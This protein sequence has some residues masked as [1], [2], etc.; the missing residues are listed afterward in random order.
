MSYRSLRSILFSISVCSIFLISASPL[1]AQQGDL[2]GRVLDDRTDEPI[3]GV[4]IYLPELD[5]GTASD[6]EGRFAIEGLPRDEI[7]LR[8]SSVGYQTREM[9]I[10]ID[11]EQESV[12]L[13]LQED[14]IGLDEL[15]V[16]GQGQ[17]MER[18][19]LS[20]NVTSISANDIDRLPTIRLDQILQ[21]NLSNA[22]VRFTSGEPGTASLVRGRGVVSALTATTPVVY[23]DGVR[24]DQ[25][26]GFNLYQGTGGAQ[27]S[28]L[29][30][31]PVENI[32]RIE[33]VSG[34]AATTLYGS[35]AA[36][37]VIQIFTKHGTPGA[38]RFEVG[39][40][41]GQTRATRDY[42]RYDETGDILFSPGVLQKYHLS[43]SGGSEQV[44]YS[45][46]GSMSGDEG[47]LPN[48]DQ[49]RHSL[50]TSLQA[51]V[52][53]NVDYRGSF[54]FSNHEFSRDWNANFAGGPLDIEKANFGNPEEWDTAE[55][56]ARRDYIRGYLALSEMSEDVK[57]Y[58]TSQQLE[59][60]LHPDLTARLVAGVDSRQSGQYIY[61]TNAYMIAYGF[62]PSGTT[63]AG[64]LSET[65]RN[66][67]GLTLEA[68]L[69][70]E[71][72]WRRWNLVSQVGG[73][74][75]RNDE[76]QMQVTADGVPDGSRL[77]G[78]GS[79][80]SGANFRRTLVN[81]GGY[82]LEN[83][84]YD[85]RYF[86]ELAI[87]VDQNSA[88]GETIS[89]QTYPKV[90]TVWNLAGEPLLRDALESVQISTLRLRGNLGWAGNF[91]T[92]FSNEV[93]ASIRPFRDGQAIEFGTA[94]DP[95]LKPERTR[96]LEAGFD[97]GL[98][99]DRVIFEASWYNSK[100]EDALFRAPFPPSSGLGSAL[101]NV[102]TIE[103]RGVE[104]ATRVNVLQ[105][106]EANVGVR[107]SLNT[108]YNEV[109]DNG[110]TSPFAVG[111]FGFLGSWVDEDHP[112]GHFR[113]NRP[114][115]GADGSLQ[116]VE[117]DEPL[118]SPLPDL[119]GS[120]GFTADWRSWS[121]LASADYQLGAQGVDMDEIFRFIGGHQDGRVPE[122]AVEDAG[123]NYTLFSSEWVEDTDYLKVRFVSLGYELPESWLGNRFRSL[124][125]ALTA[126]NP[127]NWTRANFD[128]E[129]SGQGVSRGQGEIGVGGF[130]IGTLS[131]P[132]QYTLRIRAGF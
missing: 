67:L 28:A 55:Y 4:S 77:A 71:T 27:S 86:L 68:T 37:G 120:L 104:L 44:Q 23:I 32:E 58:Q 116:D 1:M 108:L 49:V 70:H 103:N 128:P 95:A 78:S 47:V 127:L 10:R 117:F 50:R 90:G 39:A 18:Y 17:G 129:V 60:D 8:L 46:S 29:A 79:S 36:N 101:Q 12:T 43:G 107:A 122:Q 73:Q 64:R 54:A 24:V 92:P 53:E 3:P 19:R 7:T 119:F 65:T 113:G 106:S 126:T 114:V 40:A 99:R 11:D 118:G 51:D 130:A 75:F 112:V 31:I 109:T 111:G 97:L 110:G 35:D 42:L 121:L 41:L 56:E 131:S 2:S 20:T 21:A 115:Y 15:V 84:G 76:R 66:F 82:W 22:Q 9:S 57:R 94:G 69:R 59:L 83:L 96:T 105:T 38:S 88:F 87:R 85:N 26:T 102:G 45:F 16:T 98:L 74:L 62:E 34:G 33:V 80:S 48:N 72:D 14:R 61:D 123:G 30:D 5:R 6:A 124:S 25:T 125:L 89:A 91:P 13:S 93:L 100:T 63:D 81:Y 132:R 52:H